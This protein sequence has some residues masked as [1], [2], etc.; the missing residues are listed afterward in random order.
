ME[1]WNLQPASLGL[2]GSQANV[3]NDYNTALNN[4][5]TQTQ[6]GATNLGQATTELT[7]SAN[8]CDQTD[9]SAA[10]ALKAIRG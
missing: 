5:I 7:N 4:V 9:Q 8:A 6:T 1:T 2:L 3:I 10:D